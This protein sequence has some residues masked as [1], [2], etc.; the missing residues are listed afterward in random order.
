MQPTAGDVASTATFLSLLRGNLNAVSPRKKR[1]HYQFETLVVNNLDE[2][3][4][5]HREIADALRTRFASEDLISAMMTDTSEIDIARKEMRTL[6]DQA[7]P[8]RANDPLALAVRYLDRVNE[9]MELRIRRTWA[10]H[11]KKLLNE[12]RL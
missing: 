3:K 11:Q 12:A 6:Y 7:A 5:T 8:N 1:S 2:D 4:A 9:E 10:S